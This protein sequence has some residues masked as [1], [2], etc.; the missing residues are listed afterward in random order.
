MI[1]AFMEFALLLGDRQVKRKLNTMK[2]TI[3]GATCSLEK[4]DSAH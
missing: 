3:T 2:E 1:S 4:S